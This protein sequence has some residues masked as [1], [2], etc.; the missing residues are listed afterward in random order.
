MGVADPLRK[1]TKMETID[2]VTLQEKVED[3]SKA[4]FLA[5]KQHD[6]WVF[7]ESVLQ[8]LYD[9]SQ[10]ILHIF[11]F[12]IWKKIFLFYL[13][14]VLKFFSTCHICFSS[15]P[16]T[17]ATS[18]FHTFSEFLDPFDNAARF[19]DTMDNNSSLWL[20]SAGSLVSNR[21]ISLNVL[22]SSPLAFAS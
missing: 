22:I 11:L 7:V 5:R 20:F 13:I 19:D 1:K 6:P 10:Y 18:E 8:N 9:V 15:F 12:K 16:K 3:L 2:L 21:N 4:L 17:F 14:F